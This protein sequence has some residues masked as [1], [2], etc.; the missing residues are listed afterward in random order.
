M[1]DPLSGEGGA[2][3]AGAS[4]ADAERAAARPWQ[5]LGP[6]WVGVA[7]LMM[8]TVLLMAENLRFFGYAVGVT[9]G[10][11]ALLRAVLPERRAGGLRVRGK[12][13]DVLTLTLLGLAIAVLASSL[14]LGA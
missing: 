1:T 6:W 14:R 3:R 8:A 11:L 4:D 7:G 5:P 9:M 2:S 13:F 12:A 10:V